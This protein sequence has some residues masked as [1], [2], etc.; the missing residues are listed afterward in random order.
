MIFYSIIN[1][2]YL[3]ILL[4]VFLEGNVLVI[5]YYKY[6]LLLKCVV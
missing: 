2:D 6:F 4:S 5:Y 3:L 1:D